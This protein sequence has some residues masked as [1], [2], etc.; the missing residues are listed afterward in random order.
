MSGSPVTSSTTRSGS[1]SAEFAG[2]L[3]ETLDRNGAR[4][5]AAVASA[6]WW[7]AHSAHYDDTVRALRCPGHHHSASR[8]DGGDRRRPER[9]SRDGRGGRDGY[10]R[11]GEPAHRRC[12]RGYGGHPDGA[13]SPSRRRGVRPV[14]GAGLVRGRRRSRLVAPADPYDYGG[15]VPADAMGGGP[16]PPMQFEPETDQY[17]RGAG[18]ARSPCSSL[19]WSSSFWRSRWPCGLCCAITR[20]PRRRHRPP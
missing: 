13:R 9:R 2:V 16:R 3:Q 17:E 14:V 19:A 12:G 5:L 18:D 8:A 10:G 4:G 6:G 7:R 15:V 20:A 1:R 11:S